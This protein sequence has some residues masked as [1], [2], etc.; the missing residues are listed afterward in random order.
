MIFG[1]IGNGKD[2]GVICHY[3]H[4]VIS[5]NTYRHLHLHIYSERKRTSTQ[6]A[7]NLFD[8]NG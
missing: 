8:A 6:T 5:L 4:T 1:K 2:V 7:I 3:F